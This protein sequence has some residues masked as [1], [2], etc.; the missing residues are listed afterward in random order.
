MI[1]SSTFNASPLCFST[2]ETPASSGDQR[3]GVD[4]VYRL[5]T[6]DEIMRD[7]AVERLPGYFINGE[8]EVER[9]LPLGRL[10]RESNEDV[11][12]GAERESR[13]DP[14]WIPGAFSKQAAR[15]CL[16]RALRETGQLV[17]RSA[18]GL[19]TAWFAGIG[20][21]DNLF[22]ELRPRGIWVDHDDLVMGEMC[23]LADAERLLE[24]MYRGD[25]CNE[26]SVSGGLYRG[27][28]SG[29]PEPALV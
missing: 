24:A 19:M 29:S 9:T 21:A 18:D 11:C 8:G 2:C 6:T 23:S 22:V 13:S 28:S 15:C 7:R 10:S 16:Y 12:C 14:I 20:D 5:S 26:L 17:V 4:G 1:M 3:G 25:S 27:I